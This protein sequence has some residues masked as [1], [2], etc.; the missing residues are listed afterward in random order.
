[1]DILTKDANDEAA[2]QEEK[3]NR[4]QKIMLGIG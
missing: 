2:R 3:I 1:M 4:R